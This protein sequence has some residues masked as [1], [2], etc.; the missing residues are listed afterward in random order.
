MKKII[1]IIAAVS[2]VI[3]SGCQEKGPN[4]KA[5]EKVD[6]A[7]DNMKQGDSPFKEKGAMEKMGESIDESIKKEEK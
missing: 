4:E 2:L 6:A 7:I 1:V 5:G 3:L